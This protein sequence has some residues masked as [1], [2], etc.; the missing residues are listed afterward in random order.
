MEQEK[1]WRQKEERKKKDGRE[2]R[3]TR[4]SS[5]VKGGEGRRRLK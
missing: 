4:K 1:E 5:L 3:R 2:K